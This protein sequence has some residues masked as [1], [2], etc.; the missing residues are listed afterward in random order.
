MRATAPWDESNALGELLSVLEAS[1][2][3][4]RARLMQALDGDRYSA[5]LAGLKQELAE[6]ESPDPS[7][8]LRDFV[9]PILRKRYRKL[10]KDAEALTADSEASAYHQARIRG[11]KLRYSVEFVRP[12]YEKPAEVMADAMVE[13]QDLLGQH[14]DDVVAI[15]WLRNLVRE[16]GRDLA[17]QTLLFM[18]ELTARERQEMAE[19]REA[20]PDVLRD[21][22]KC[23]RKLDKAIDVEAKA[24]TEALFVDEPAPAPALTIP[25]AGPRLRRWQR[26]P[27]ALLRRRR[28][29]AD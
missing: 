6:R 18:G 21:V 10:R 8:P 22:R 15:D 26:G 17:P 9:A 3:E 25:G 29:G 27:F 24:E 16:R 23:W 7:L 28:H 13:M 12:L 1:H 19:L 14:Q 20:W 4:A 11:K 2:V 5:I